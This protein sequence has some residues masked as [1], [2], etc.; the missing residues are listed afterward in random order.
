MK[1]YTK[2]TRNYD[3]APAGT[4]P[5]NPGQVAP[6]QVAGNVLTSSGERLRFERLISD[7]SA[8]FVDIVPDR[9][10]GEI[11]NA[12]KQVLEFFQVDRGGLVGT[13]WQID[14]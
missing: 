7:L 3:I 10:D 11:E 9:V 2:M 6:I 1:C 12:L 13:P 5:G 14:S 8:R 4:G